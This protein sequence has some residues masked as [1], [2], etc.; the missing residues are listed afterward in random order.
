MQN[1]IQ[2]LVR[3]R[4]IPGHVYTYV[5]IYMYNNSSI[6]WCFICVDVS[7]CVGRGA[8]SCFYQQKSPD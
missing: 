3:D 1:V 2:A 4:W 8:L 6:G 7:A 5:S